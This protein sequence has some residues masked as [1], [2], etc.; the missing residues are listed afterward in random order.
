MCSVGLRPTGALEN[1]L[2]ARVHRKALGLKWPQIGV[3]GPGAPAG[4]RDID[5]TTAGPL[6]I[7]GV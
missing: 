3:T 7:A 4:G 6:P 2:G 5:A 1:L